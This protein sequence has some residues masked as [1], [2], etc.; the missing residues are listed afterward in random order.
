MVIRKNLDFEN[1]YWE[2][3][4][5]IAGVDEAGR[6]SLAGPLVVASVVLPKY[7]YDERIQD[8]KTISPKKRE[9][10]CKFIKRICL[11]YKISIVKIEDIEKKNPLQSTKD[12]MIECIKKLRVKP[13]LC[14]VDGKEE[15][16]IF[17]L[18][19]ISI[20][21]GDNKSINIAA[22]SIIA[23]VTR[24]NIMKGLHLYYPEYK[25]NENKGYLNKYHF[26]VLIKKGPCK[27]HRKNY[28]PVKTLL[29]KTFSLLDLK[30]KYPPFW[31]L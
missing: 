1:E 5:L 24:D 25:W 28:E 11:D 6:G 23:K 29:K 19:T 2:K 16:S 4:P 22:A 27:F 20:I 14:L 15:I 30:K 18:P 3:Y 10:L 26:S 31:F 17:D 8:S 21:K 7:M 12:G 13:D 9:F